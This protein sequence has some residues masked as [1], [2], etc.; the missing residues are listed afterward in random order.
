MLRLV[1]VA[2]CENRWLLLW[3][4]SS[5]GRRAGCRRLLDCR[6][7]PIVIDMARILLVREDASTGNMERC[8]D[9]TH[10]AV[11]D[12]AA[13]AIP[14]QEA[15]SVNRTVLVNAELVSSR[16]V[17]ASGVCVCQGYER[18]VRRGAAAE[19]GT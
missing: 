17:V 2:H 16:A 8:A 19:N 7:I 5:S 3:L 14:V 10:V 12:S 15:H 11:L 13:L 9:G 18:A 1:H 6:E 4:F